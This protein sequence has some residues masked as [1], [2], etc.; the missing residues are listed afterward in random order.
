MSVNEQLPI[1]PPAFSILVALNQGQY[2]V[3]KC[4]QRVQ[5]IGNLV[6][7]HLEQE[8]IDRC[9]SQ[10]RYFFQRMQPHPYGPIAYFI[11]H[12]HPLDPNRMLAEI[13]HQRCKLWQIFDDDLDSQSAFTERDEMMQGCSL[14]AAEYFAFCFRLLVH[15][16]VLL[17][18]T[19]ILQKN[20]RLL[21]KTEIAHVLF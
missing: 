3:R 7:V 6:R 21:F 2:P 13:F 15:F 18:G 8:E 20:K 12:V 9:I 17:S 4:Y 14:Y 10:I 19:I 16:L 11:V 1:E 5:G